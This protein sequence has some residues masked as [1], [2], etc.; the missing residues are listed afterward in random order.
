MKSL[1]EK[2]AARIIIT[3]LIALVTIGIVTGIGVPYNVDNYDPGHSP[4]EIGDPNY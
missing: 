2:N 1:I 4:L 3:T